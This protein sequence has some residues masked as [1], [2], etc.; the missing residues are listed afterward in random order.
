MSSIGRE[1]EELKG[2]VENHSQVVKK[3]LDSIRERMAQCAA[4]QKEELSRYEAKISQF[5]QSHRDQAQKLRDSARL[6]LERVLDEELGA[7]SKTVSD[8]VEETKESAAAHQT[9][10]LEVCQATTEAVATAGMTV[11]QMTTEVNACESML[12]GEVSSAARALK[13][14]E[15]EVDELNSAAVQQGSM[16]VDKGSQGSQ[17]HAQALSDILDST[18]SASKSAVAKMRE[19]SESVREAVTEFEAAMSGQVESALQRSEESR[20]T[21]VAMHRQNEIVSGEG[22]ANAVSLAS[23]FSDHA[24]QFVDKWSMDGVTGTTPAK[25]KFEYITE[26]PQCASDAD[27]VEQAKRRRVGSLQQDEAEQLQSPSETV[28]EAVEEPETLVE[29][30]ADTSSEASE[31]ANMDV[32]EAPAAKAPIS[33]GA[34]RSNGAA[35]D[36]QQRRPRGREPSKDRMAARSKSTIERRR[37]ASGTAASRRTAT[38]QKRAGQPRPRIPLSDMNSRA[39]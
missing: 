34:G 29:E 6:A 35:A 19:S 30:A 15:E 38:Q 22:I 16:I 25:R 9:Q 13:A 4:M 11:S 20:S 24:Q 36:R 28:G 21:A 39:R 12:T 26:L 17:L 33:K 8:V 27:I 7:L 18:Q 32:E 37:A 10:Q 14:F 5:Q 31:E 2:K 23:A 1:G 3:V